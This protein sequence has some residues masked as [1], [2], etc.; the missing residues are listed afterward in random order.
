MHSIL[1][2]SDLIQSKVSQ[3]CQIVHNGKGNVDATVY[4]GPDCS[5][6]S[7]YYNSCVWDD[8]GLEEGDSLLK[9]ERNV[10]LFL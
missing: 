3:G 1:H 5:V 10:P 8:S 6:M 2:R 4:F 9:D 7:S